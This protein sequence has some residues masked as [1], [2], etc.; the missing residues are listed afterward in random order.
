M[1]VDA[2]VEGAV[3]GVQL[4]LQ[5]GG[6]A[7]VR[8]GAAEAPEQLRLFVRGGPHQPPIGRDELDRAKAVDRE[9]EAPLEPPDAAAEGQT[10]DARVADDA[11][12]TDEPVLLR[13]DVQGS[14]E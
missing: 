1:D 9:P 8:A 3:E 7:E 10:G 4:E 2:A 11:D 5:A 12:G 6:D 14:E 13:G